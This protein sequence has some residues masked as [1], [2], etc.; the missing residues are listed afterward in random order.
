MGLSG[1][2]EKTLMWLVPHCVH[3]L[4]NDDESVNIESACAAGQWE[5][6]LR[7]LNDIVNDFDSP[8]EVAVVGAACL[9]VYLCY[10]CRKSPW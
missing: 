5:T 1:Q 8:V 9:T 10:Y 3:L 7:L 4:A 2:I 6:G